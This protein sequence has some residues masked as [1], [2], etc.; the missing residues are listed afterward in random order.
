MAQG[1]TRYE[2]T[3]ENHQGHQCED[4]LNEKHRQ[5]VNICDEFVTFLVIYA[6]GMELFHK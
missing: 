5:M 1:I 2:A 4:I 3:T 6:T